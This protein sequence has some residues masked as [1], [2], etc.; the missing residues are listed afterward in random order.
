MTRHSLQ[1]LPSLKIKTTKMNET[2]LEL[3]VTGSSTS[4]MLKTLPPQSSPPSYP[5]VA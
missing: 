5:L 3:E 2:K 1:S 4:I